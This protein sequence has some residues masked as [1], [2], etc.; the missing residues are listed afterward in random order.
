MK[1][2][3]VNDI[4]LFAYPGFCFVT[5]NHISKAAGNFR[6]LQPLTVTV[7]Y[8]LTRS[9]M[10]AEAWLKLINLPDVPT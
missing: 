8:I 5:L 6:T 3:C 2:E 1:Q 9:T 10:S 7:Y 4:T